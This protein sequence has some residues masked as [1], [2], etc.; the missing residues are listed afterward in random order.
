VDDSSGRREW[1]VHPVR[2]RSPGRGLARGK[3][4]PSSTG[5]LQGGVAA[6]ST[7]TRLNLF[8]SKVVWHRAQRRYNVSVVEEFQGGGW[9]AH[10]GSACGSLRGPDV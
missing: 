5:G 2:E 6:M 4:R 9:T 7:A 10:A 3:S 1:Q 8:L